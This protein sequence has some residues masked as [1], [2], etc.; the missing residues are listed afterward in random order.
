VGPDWRPSNIVFSSFSFH[1]A[2]FLAF[3][4]EAGFKYF[5]L[6]YLIGVRKFGIRRAT[7][8]MR[9]RARDPYISSTLIGGKGGAGQ[10]RFPLRLRD[11]RNTP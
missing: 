1:H 4:L 6:L 5:R 10:V 8:H 2:Y 9:L 11:Q 7:S 3:K